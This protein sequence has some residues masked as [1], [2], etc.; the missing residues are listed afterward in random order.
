MYACYLL[1]CLQ[2]GKETKCYVGST[3]DPIRRLRQHNGEIQG[4]AKKTSKARPWRMVVVVHG[5]PNK[6]AA[7]QFEWAWYQPVLTSLKEPHTVHRHSQAETAP[8]SSL[9]NLRAKYILEFIQAP[10]TRI[11]I[12]CSCRYGAFGSMGTMAARSACH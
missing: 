6:I 12:E 7:L 3:P 9:S 1:K 2:P 10:A 11:Q 5:F 4:G 8:I